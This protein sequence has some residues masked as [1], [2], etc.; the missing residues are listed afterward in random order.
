MNEAESFEVMWIATAHRSH[1][2]DISGFLGIWR[3]WRLLYVLLVFS[4]TS[5]EIKEN[6]RN[7]EFDVIAHVSDIDKY[8]A[9]N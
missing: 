7:V 4:I 5:C 6:N 1:T 3:C 2:F 9:R 8:S